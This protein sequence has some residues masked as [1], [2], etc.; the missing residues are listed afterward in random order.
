MFVVKD[1]DLFATQVIPQYFDH[2][3]FSSFARQLN[4]YGFRKMQ[5]KPI[6]N[7]DFDAETAKHVTF[8]NEN[9]KRGRCELLKKIQRSTRGGGSTNPQDQSREIQL[10]RD[11]ISN[12]EMKIVE[13]EA[14][15][16]ERVRRLELDLLARMDQMMMNYRQHQNQIQPLPPAV[17][18]QVQV[19]KSSSVGTHT[20]G[21]VNSNQQQQIQHSLPQ[22]HANHIQSQTSINQQS[23]NGIPNSWDPNAFSFNTGTAINSV[24][25]AAATSYHQQQQQQVV[26]PNG[27]GQGTTATLPPHPKQKLLPLG[28]MPGMMSA[29]PDR[30]NSLRGISALT[31]GLSGLSRGASVESALFDENMFNLLMMETGEQ[32]VTGNETSLQPNPIQDQHSTQY[33]QQ[34]LQKLNSIMPAFNPNDGM[35]RNYGGTADN[36]NDREDLSDVSNDQA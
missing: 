11:Q 19:E 35:Y 14:A 23:L 16:E 13:I 34:A 20:S 33:Q 26:P 3:K 5:S 31:R 18:L 12:L 27:I 7:S 9:F 24:I 2:N 10:L 22:Q 36:T 17:P 25:S 6:R 4:F 8:F 32:H 29:P 15:T 1:P 21:S 28:G 30:M